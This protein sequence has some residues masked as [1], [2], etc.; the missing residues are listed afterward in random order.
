[1]AYS[2]PLPQLRAQKTKAGQVS[3]PPLRSGIP[4]NVRGALGLANILPMRLA[5]FAAAV[6][7]FRHNDNQLARVRWYRF[8]RKD[9]DE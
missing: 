5:A 9:D 7:A 2:K 6:A 3:P 8:T 4:V 1:M